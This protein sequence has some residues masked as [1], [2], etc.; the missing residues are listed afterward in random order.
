MDMNLTTR[1]KR[2]RRAALA[3]ASKG[4]GK[5]VYRPST[6]GPGWLPRAVFFR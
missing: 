4:R 5:K 1:R 2:D 3:A 6:A